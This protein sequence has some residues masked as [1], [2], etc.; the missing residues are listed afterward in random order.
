MQDPDFWASCADSI[1]LSIEGNRLIVRELA[2]LVRGYWQRV[3][4]SFD[5]LLHGGKRHLPPL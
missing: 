1:E 5:E 4:R 2:D 3:V